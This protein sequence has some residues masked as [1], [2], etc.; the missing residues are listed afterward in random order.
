MGSVLTMYKKMHLGIDYFESKMSA[1]RKKINR[2][3]I[4]IMELIFGVIIAYFGFKL[5]NIVGV[6]KSPVMRMRMVYAYVVLP[7]SGVLYIIIAIHEL[8]THHKE[9]KEISPEVIK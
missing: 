6:Q 8:I 7:I 3:F 9:S 2:Y 4:Y 5:L 1:K